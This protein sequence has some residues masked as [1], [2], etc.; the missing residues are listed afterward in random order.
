MP[1][2]YL[3][4][5]LLFLASCA[6]S[7]GS[8]VPNMT[9]RHVWTNERTGETIV[10]A[11]GTAEVGGRAY[12]LRDCSTP[13]MLC[14]ES[15]GPIDLAVNRRCDETVAL[16][17]A[18]QEMAIWSINH[19]S[20]VFGRRHSPQLLYEYSHRYGITAIYYVPPGLATALE[21]GPDHSIRH[22]HR[23]T[24]SGGPPF[25]PCR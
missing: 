9:A 19:L 22:R 15:D 11:N 13:D 25:L 14:V 16:R 23:F 10:V 12:P 17:V 20:P 6:G 24:R 5:L 7:A 18:G 1:M 8:L 21:A 2:N 3:P 4:I